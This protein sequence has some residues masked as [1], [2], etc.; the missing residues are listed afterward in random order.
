MPKSTEFGEGNAAR[1]FVE[2]LAE[3]SFW[4]QNLQKE[5]CEQ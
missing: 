5:F 1:K 3:H 4:E 2:T